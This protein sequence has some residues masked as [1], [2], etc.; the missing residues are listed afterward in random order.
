MLTQSH[1]N[2]LYS[3]HVLALL[4]LPSSY[5]STCTAS[6]GRDKRCFR[7]FFFTFMV[8]IVTE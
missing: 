6:T 2:D 8:K 3:M 4:Q 5:I 7:A 1:K